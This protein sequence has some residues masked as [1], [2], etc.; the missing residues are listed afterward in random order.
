MTLVQ[1][2]KCRVKDTYI[3]IFAECDIT[4]GKKTGMLINHPTFKN[5]ISHLLFN[6][7]RM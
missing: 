5:S 1:V 7:Q 6:S 4:G 3:L 2:V